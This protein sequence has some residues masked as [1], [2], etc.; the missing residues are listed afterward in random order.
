VAA[1]STKRDNEDE[2]REP[3][4]AALLL[5]AGEGL[6]ATHALVS[7]S[8][9][10]GRAPECDLVVDR[11]TLSRRH[12][13]LRSGSPATI[14]DL[15]SRNGTRVGN[16]LHR[17]GAPVPLA[18]GDVFHIGNVAFMLL[19]APQAPS[20]RSEL[21]RPLRVIDPGRDRATAHVREIAKSGTNVLVLGETGVGKEVLVETLHHWSERRGPL[22]RIN[23][24]ALSDTLLESELFGH[25]K[26]AFTGAT[27]SRVGLISAADRGTL[28]LDEVGELSPIAQ[29]KL[30]R[31]IETKEVM[32]IGAVTPKTIDVRFVAA[33]NRDLPAEAAHGRFRADLLYRLDGVTVEIPPLRQRP[34][35][36]APLAWQFLDEA[37]RAAGRTPTPLPASLLGL[38]EQHDWPGNVR[39]LKTAI[40]RASLL[41]RGAALGPQHFTLR[42][43]PASSVTRSHLQSA[44][45]T[46]PDDEYA[47]IVAAL[48]ACAGNQTRAARM[49]GVSRTTL[50]HKIALLRIPRPRA[51]K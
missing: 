13:C 16:V 27:E 49:L 9:I 8:L 28:M 24:A 2:A 1:N 32:P 29:A 11:A 5:V 4:E 17:G 50:V 41:A 46:P 19:D 30:L 15:G 6:L 51:R 23:C 42:A 37:E 26:G 34:Q 22:V 12:A 20:A 36:V 3:R 25:E 18:V 10:I 48:E 35:L 40:G 39:E 47:R 45:P 38:L 31:V 44:P 43:T 14:Q 7:P 33:T 21:G